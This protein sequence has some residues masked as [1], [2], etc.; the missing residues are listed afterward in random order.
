M[1]EESKPRSIHPP[2]A[3]SLLLELKK[4]SFE[5]GGSIN[6]TLKRDS[7]QSENDVM[8]AI[9]DILERETGTRWFARPASRVPPIW[10]LHNPE[11]L[12]IATDPLSVARS[13]HVHLNR[14]GSLTLSVSRS[15]S[16]Y[17]HRPQKKDS[18]E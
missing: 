1:T 10:V 16:H 13:S 17:Y 2:N 15:N 8:K 11:D 14:S 5:E 18:P 12:L 7:F 6:V 3:L 9:A 4:Y